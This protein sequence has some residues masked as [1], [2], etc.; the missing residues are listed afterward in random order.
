MEE[1]TKMKPTRRVNSSGYVQSLLL[2]RVAGRLI[3]LFGYYSGA[4]TA[5]IQLHEA[6]STTGLAGAVPFH[7]FAIGATDNYSVIVPVSGIPFSR[8]LIAVVSTTED[9]YTPYG[10]NI[11]TMLAT[12]EAN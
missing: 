11:A 7:T 8:A 12:L 2:S 6:N 9:T 1:D 10:S 3:S 4:A 5:W